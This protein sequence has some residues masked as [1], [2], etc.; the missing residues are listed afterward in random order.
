MKTSAGILIIRGDE[1]L[2]GHAT[3]SKRYDIP[4]GGI[5]EGETGRSAAV[6]ETKEE[7]GL[8]VDPNKLKDIGIF[9]YLQGK[10]L[11]L[12]IYEVDKFPKIS[13][14]ICTEYFTMY[15]RSYPEIDGYKV[16]KIKDIQKVVPKGLWNIISN[17]QLKGK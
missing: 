1:I 13:D 4:K 17:L 7:F 11:H 3:N 8:T 10:N 16:F 14:L 12:F 2:L 5:E 9:R 6:R 15:G